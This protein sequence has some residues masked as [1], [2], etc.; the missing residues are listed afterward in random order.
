V[1]YD[2]SYIIASGVLASE[3]PQLLF[4]DYDQFVAFTANILLR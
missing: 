1:C 2:G 3:M 4:D